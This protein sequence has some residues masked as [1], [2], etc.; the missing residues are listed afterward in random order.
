MDPS[1]SLREL[2]KLSHLYYERQWMFATAGNLSYREPGSDEFWITASGKHKGEL[3][4]TD[5]VSVNVQ[6]GNVISAGVGLKPSAETTIH[7]V[8]YK[9]L[10]SA[11]AALHVHT[12][13]SNLLDYSLSPKNDIM[14]VQVP[15]IEMIKAF[16]IWD[17]KPNL[18]MPV[19]YN[20]GSVPKIA[21]KI[22]SY[23]E[24]KGAP[25]LP[26]L[27][28]EGHGPTVWGNSIAEANRHLEAVSFL[29]K[30]MAYQK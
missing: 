6:S 11:N 21:D 13:E 26:F 7:R 28:I 17:E 19:F 12:I 29:F 22:E 4:E 8:V 2:T 30:V 16:G 18:T 23:F 3:G 1:V 5:F 27:L 20:Y 25:K 9:H 24:T 15:P 10:T 14:E